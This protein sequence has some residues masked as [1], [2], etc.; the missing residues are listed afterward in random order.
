VDGRPPCL[1]LLVDAIPFDLA[2]EAW[3]E[4]AMPGFREPLPSVSVFPS[5]T[6]V[7][8]P[9]LLRPA[10]G[11]RP[12]GYEARWYHPPSGEL[13]G[14]GD[15]ASEAALAPFQGRPRGVLGQAA[16][17]VLRASLA[18][19]QVRWITHRFAREGGPWLGYVSATD[20]V[21]HF[22]GRPGLRRAFD[23]VLAAVDA[24][25]REHRARTGAWPDA[26]LCSDHG[27]AFGRL[28]H[29]SEHALAEH[30]AGAG[31]RPGARGR[32][33]VVLV[34]WGEVGS[35]VAHVERARAP[36][37]AERVAGA[38]GVELAFGADGAG[39]LVFGENGARARLAWRGE[40][41]RYEPLAGD[42]LG[43]AAVFEALARDGALDADGF[44]C[45][46]A[47]FAAS[48]RA[49]FPDA[50]AR[51]RRGLEDLV[52]HPAPVLFS[53]REDWTFGPAL[54][55]AGAV[56][57][58]GQVG[59]HGGLSAAQSLGFA[60]ANEEAGD[61]WPGAHA[62]RSEQVFAPWRTLLQS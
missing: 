51:V 43:Y 19:A 13:R 40:R 54:T 11:A 58:G 4:G 17:Y 62:L 50:L 37:L 44:V 46:A 53:M 32:D 56:L 45:D 47:L 22:A 24:V 1:F 16:L 34:P 3:N 48:W 49:P 38:P 61:P 23:G 7:A 5:L 26:V 14:P 52:E 35:G 15:P 12:P 55:H 41:Y 57:L 27:M 60:A 25:R 10:G 31:F 39:C 18:Y 36:E 9:T 30:L 33:G 42:P 8:V 2:W 28:H 6:D 21:G 29:L 59:T 20:G